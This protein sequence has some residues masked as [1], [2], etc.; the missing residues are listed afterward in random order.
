MPQPT[1][2]VADGWTNLESVGADLAKY[3]DDKCIG[4]GGYV[5]DDIGDE[6]VRWIAALKTSP[7]L[8][9]GAKQVAQDLFNGEPYLAVHWRFEE[10][11]C[12]G[13]GKG[14]GYGRDKHEL[15]RQG[16]AG[17]SSHCAG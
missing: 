3:D 6:R 4:V 17:L 1:I 9:Q 5:P 10:T 14:I 12:A 8:M 7:M 15:V 2:H 16:G 11:K 13:Y